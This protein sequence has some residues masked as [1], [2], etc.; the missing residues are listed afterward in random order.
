MIENLLYLYEE[1]FSYEL[2]P[3]L[4]EEKVTVAIEYDNWSKELFR[5]LFSFISVLGKKGCYKAALEFNKVINFKFCFLKLI[6]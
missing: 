4:Q 6:Y 3:L 5:T 2:F 1:S